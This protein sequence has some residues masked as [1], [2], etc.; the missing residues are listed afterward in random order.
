MEA[1]EVSVLNLFQGDISLGLKTNLDD[2]EGTDNDA[3]S[4]STAQSGQ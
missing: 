1:S 4:E 3:L 2:L